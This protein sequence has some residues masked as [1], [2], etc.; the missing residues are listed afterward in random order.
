V[1]HGGAAECYGCGGHLS[2]SDHG[3]WGKPPWSSPRPVPSEL[4][5]AGSVDWPGICSGIFFYSGI[6]T[7]SDATA[8]V[9]TNSVPYLDFLLVQSA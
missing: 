8:K 2:S 9:K 5:Q 4:L 3:A 6:P 1:R 7:A